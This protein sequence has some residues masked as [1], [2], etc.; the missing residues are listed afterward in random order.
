MLRLV[1][2]ISKI[3]S[4]N[5]CKKAIPNSSVDDLFRNKGQ[6]EVWGRFAGL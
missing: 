6:E 2:H 4:Y 5:I 3:M 1:L